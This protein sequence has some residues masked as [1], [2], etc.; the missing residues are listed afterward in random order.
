[1]TFG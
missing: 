1:M